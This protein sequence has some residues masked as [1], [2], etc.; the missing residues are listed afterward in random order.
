M[1]LLQIKKDMQRLKGTYYITPC[2]KL[3][4][5]LSREIKLISTKGLKKDFIN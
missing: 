2:E 4:I 5:D 1:K 3:I